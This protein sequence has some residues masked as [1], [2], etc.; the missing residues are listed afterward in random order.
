MAI[1]LFPHS[2]QRNVLNVKEIGLIL[3]AKQIRWSDKFCAEI[4]TEYVNESDTFSKL[5]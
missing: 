1:I 2:P 3:E 4:L 5:Q